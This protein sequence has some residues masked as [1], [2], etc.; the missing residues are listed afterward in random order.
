M[1]G[2]DAFR[3]RLG[4]WIDRVAAGES[5]LV[6]RRGKAVMRVEQPLS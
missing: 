6:C 5:L 3:E 1:I 2:V 4:R